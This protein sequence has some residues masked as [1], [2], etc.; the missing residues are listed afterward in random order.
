LYWITYIHKLLTISVTDVSPAALVVSV[1]R[2]WLF[3]AVLIVDE[4]GVAIITEVGVSDCGVTVGGCVVGFFVVVVVVVPAVG[5]SSV[6]A[7]G[8][9][10]VVVVVVEDL[11]TKHFN[12]D[13]DTEPKRY[14]YIG[15]A[16]AVPPD[17]C[18]QNYQT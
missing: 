4:A 6:A 13:C 3:N 1:E 17:C 18:R 16:D 8:S 14:N 5:V 7:G 2:D 15:D 12:L 11:Q 9:V 10:V